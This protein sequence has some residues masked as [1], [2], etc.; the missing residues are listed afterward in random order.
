MATA[1]VTVALMGVAAA[2]TGAYFTDSKSGTITGTMGTIKVTGYDGGGADN[3]DISFTK[4]LPGESQDRS[5]RFQNT[6]ENSQDVW[7]V[8]QSSDLHNLNT[9]GSYGEVHVKAN[10]AAVFDSAN[11]NDG[12]PCGT[13]S[14]GFP[15]ICP[16]PSQI[17]LAS[18]VNPGDVGSMTFTFK[19]G[20]KFK[21]GV[22][23]LPVVSLR[24]KIVATQ[25]GI[26]PDNALNN[27]IVF[28]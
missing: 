24:Y 18:N 4:L 27:A 20:E 26:A 3:L 10:G 22:Q 12:Y 28:P 13:V 16:L 15:D 19:A 17:R 23:G 1:G 25:N 2:G 7:V 8:F 9:L 11:L 5:I 14:P 6:G 21:N